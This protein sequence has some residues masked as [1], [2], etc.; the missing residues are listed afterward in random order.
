MMVIINGRVIGPRS[1]LE[2][3]C[4]IIEGG[5]I[6]QIAPTSQ[7]LWPEDAY[8][9][10]A[11]GGFVA[12]G[13]VDLHVHGALG[14]DAMEGS[15]E[16][17]AQI[18]KFHIAGGTTAMTPAT[19]TDSREKITA[20]LDAIGRAVGHNFGGAQ[21]LGAHIEGPYLSTQKCGAQPAAFVRAPDP[22]E[23]M[24]WLEREGAV[25]QMT[26]APELPGA[27]ELID[28][29]LEREIIPSG[30]HTVAN[31]EQTRAAIDRGLCQATHL[32]NA[33]SA[34]T[35]VGAFRMPGALETFLADDRVMVELVADGKHVH[36]ELLR[37]AVRAK[38]VDRIC[39]VT[40]ATA[41]A[42]LADG[43]EFN[44]GVARGVVRDGVGMKTDGSA[45]VGS[46]ATMIQLVRNMVELA[47][48][49]LVD[50]VR[51]ASMN[52]AR[53]LGLSG[54]KGG[55]EPQRDADI[56]VFSPSFVL[57]K[58]VI[59]GRVEYERPVESQ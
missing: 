11:Q 55:L 27:L 33:M 29:L 52:P 31:S 15:V 20:A 22:T 28:A 10:D 58:T 35:K 47:G 36:P 7:V 51:M 5:K 30:G 21:I 38:G 12:P 57:E 59:G 54:H 4:V 24:P 50:A 14:H 46:V 23:Y 26:L 41:G 2:Q 56:V 49:T 25:T 53:A 44:V 43:S 42:G 40:D 19:V 9:I 1:I 16:V 8:I 48:V 3:H 34:A 32:F 39:L 6:K 37:L 13:F 18:A 45:L 17:L